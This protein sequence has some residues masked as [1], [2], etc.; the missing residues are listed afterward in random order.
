MTKVYRQCKQEKSESGKIKKRI[1]RKRYRQTEKGRAGH[2]RR[3]KE[4]YH[5]ECGKSARKNYFLERQYGITLDDYNRKFAEQ[6]GC[7]A[8][9]GRHQ[10]EFKKALAVDHN[11]ETKQVRDLLCINCNRDVGVIENKDKI[12]LI[13]KYLDKWNSKKEK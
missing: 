13:K 4:S 3:A 2:N 10:S 7:C 12:E 8:I 6:N 1:S 9:C 5:T 11:R